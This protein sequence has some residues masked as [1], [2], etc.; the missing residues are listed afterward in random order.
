VVQASDDR[1]A[2]IL[3]VAE[4]DDPASILFHWTLDMNLHSIRMAV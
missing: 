4:I 1:F 2:R 3:D